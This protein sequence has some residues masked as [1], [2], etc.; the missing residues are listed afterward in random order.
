MNSYFITDVNS[1]GLFS[2][3][4]NCISEHPG[5]RS[6][7]H[8]L[9]S[10]KI[11][12]KLPIIIASFIRY[13]SIIGMFDM[14]HINSVVHRKELIACNMRLCFS[15]GKTDSPLFLAGG[16]ICEPTARILNL[17]PSTSADLLRNFLKVVKKFR[18][19]KF[20]SF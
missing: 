6:C 7:Q 2:T 9:H 1:E 18:K 8:C 10:M 15:L 4:P 3:P 20:I 19:S 14:E 12:P 13:T 11:W 17:R 16:T 5:F